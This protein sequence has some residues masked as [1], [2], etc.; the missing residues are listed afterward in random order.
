MVP[1]VD[2]WRKCRPEST[3]GSRNNNSRTWNADP[4]RLAV[5]R[6]G[7]HTTS[8]RPFPRLARRAP[9]RPKTG[10]CYFASPKPRNRCSGKHG[11]AQAER[12]RGLGWGGDGSG[13]RSYSRVRPS[14]FSRLSQPGGIVTQ[15]YPSLRFSTAVVLRMV[16]ALCCALAYLCLPSSAASVPVGSR[17]ARAAVRPE[18][19]QRHPANSQPSQ[20]GGTG[21]GPHRLQVAV[22]AHRSGRTP[23]ASCASSRSE[24]AKTSS[25]AGL[26]R[27]C[28]H[29]SGCASR[30]SSARVKPCIRS[31]LA[32]L[33]VLAGVADA[34]EFRNRLNAESISRTPG[35]KIV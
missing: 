31:V 13:A 7:L 4:S 14:Q 20:Q 30:S 34:P 11:F 32:T 24:S 12:L 28:A 26:S 33:A 16:V 27:T 15:R 23:A 25:A 29:S 8:M 19:H 5:L 17:S 6:K 2:C 35:K 22:P 18:A 21:T 10:S 3:K 9:R 1:P